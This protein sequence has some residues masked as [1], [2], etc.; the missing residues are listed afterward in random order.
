MD[1]RGKWRG[2][3]LG[4]LYFSTGRA[5]R[6]LPLVFSL[7]RLRGRVG[8]G[9]E[10]C[11][12]IRDTPTHS[13]CFASACFALKDSGRRPPMPSPASGRGD[14]AVAAVGIRKLRNVFAGRKA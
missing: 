1:F 14:A 6:S 7:P 2:G 11:A 9:V 3:R 4:L 12:G 8:E 13:R 5:S 10:T